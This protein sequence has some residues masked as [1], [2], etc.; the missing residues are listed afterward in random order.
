[1]ADAA[2]RDPGVRTVAAF[3][4]DGTLVPGDSLLPFVWRAAGPKRFSHA[5][6]RHGLRTALAA[7]AR[8]GSRD[9][10]KAAF[11]STALRG[12]PVSEVVAAGVAFSHRLEDKVHPAALD[13]IAWHRARGDELVLISASLLVYLE[14]L[15]QRLGFDAV[16]ATGLE[17]GQDGLLTGALDGLNVR[18]A[19]K[20]ARLERWLDGCP[21]EL[22]A[23]G[24]S[25]GDNEL[26]ARAD[27]G[28]RI[29][30]GRFGDVP[31]D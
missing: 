29:R 17:T 31:G 25:P 12:L 11:V 7:G 28:H 1:M 30:R 22:W 21:C 4:F 19:E 24:D 13:R 15:A 26:L 3:D 2:A 6:A 16:L 23:Y 14:P 10:A 18:G 5:V 8:V 9:A 20:V 27:H